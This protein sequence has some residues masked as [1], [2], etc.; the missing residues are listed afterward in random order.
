MIAGVKP[1]K[2]FFTTTAMPDSEWWNTGTVEQYRPSPSENGRGA[3]V[4]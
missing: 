1:T 3:S 4:M 2:G